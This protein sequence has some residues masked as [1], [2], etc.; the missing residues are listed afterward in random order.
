MAIIAIRTRLLI[1]I[2]PA[3]SPSA[4]DMVRVAIDALT[5]VFAQ[6]GAGSVKK[7]TRDL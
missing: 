5:Q 2:L 6:N 3:P 4:T 1:S 7:P